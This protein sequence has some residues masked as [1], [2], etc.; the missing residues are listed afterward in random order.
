MDLVRV[1]LSPLKRNFQ[2][3]KKVG[4]RP[5]SFWQSVSKWSWWSRGPKAAHA[6]PIPVVA[7]P[8]WANNR[9][10]TQ[11]WQAPVGVLPVTATIGDGSLNDLNQRTSGRS[12]TSWRLRFF[13]LVG[14]SREINKNVKGTR[15]FR[16]SIYVL[17]CTSANRQRRFN[18]FTGRDLWHVLNKLPPSFQGFM[19][20]VSWFDIVFD[21]FTV[22]FV[23]YISRCSSLSVLGECFLVY[24]W[25]KAN[26]ERELVL[27]SRIFTKKT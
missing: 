24:G 1:R 11:I 7:G 23:R 9:A 10:E 21:A 8:D 17:T 6:R 4:C 18:K 19:R 20:E 12:W 16:D 26:F 14:G 25:A 2:N 27:F 5:C 15:A 3:W 22:C 13:V